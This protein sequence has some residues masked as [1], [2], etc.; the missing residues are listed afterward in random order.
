MM[1]SKNNSVHYFNSLAPIYDEHTSRKGN[2]NAPSIVARRLKKYIAKVRSVLDIGI[3]TGKQVEHL[4]EMSRGLE[5]WGVDSSP[6][7]IDICASKHPDYCLFIGVFP[8]EKLEKVD[9]DLIVSTGVAEFV[10]DIEGFLI[11]VKKHLKPRGLLCFTYVPLDNDK[12]NVKSEASVVR[13][14]VN[15]S[16][17]NSSFLEIK[18]SPHYMKELQWA[19]G[20][21]VLEEFEFSAYWKDGEEIRYMGNISELVS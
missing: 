18:R 21:K 19:L 11:A 5:V 15:I 10:E 7:M 3:G 16:Q 2:W 13:S 1:A 4:V 12:H 14:S 8:E 20:F 6:R 9:F 17:R